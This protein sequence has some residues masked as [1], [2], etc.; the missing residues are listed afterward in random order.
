MEGTNKVQVSISDLP[1]PNTERLFT[2][3]LLPI[4]GSDHRQ[5]FITVRR[6]LEPFQQNITLTR[7]Q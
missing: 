7:T 5:T 6:F 3:Q 4:I 1:P 2:L